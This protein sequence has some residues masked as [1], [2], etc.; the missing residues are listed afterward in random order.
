MVGDIF[1]KP[2]RVIALEKIP[3]MREHFR[4]DAVVV[5]GENAAGGLGITSEIAKELLGEVADIITLGNHTWNKPEI[6]NMLDDDPRIIRPANY[7]EGAPGRGV[8]EVQLA[9]GMLGVISLQGRL[10]MQDI[11][12][13]FKSADR[14]LAVLSGHCKNILV[15]FHAEATSEKQAMGYYLDGRC[16]AVVGTHTHVQTADERILPAGTALL[17]DVGMTGPFNSIIGVEPKIAL[18]RFLTG[19]PSRVEVADGPAMLS[20]VLIYTDDN[21]GKAVAI[22]RLQIHEHTNLEMLYNQEIST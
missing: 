18:R 17:S 8:T 20:A 14:Q 4:L 15:D 2:G 12:C 1:G 5:N 9:T 16:S 3:R 10:F 11:D 7:P 6:Y 13:P 22:Q 21:S 19:L